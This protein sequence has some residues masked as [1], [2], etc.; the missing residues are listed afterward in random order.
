[1]EGWKKVNGRWTFK[2]EYR[3]E[4]FDCGTLGNTCER[5]AVR[6]MGNI[7]RTAETLVEA[8]LMTQDHFQD[9]YDCGDDFGP[10]RDRS[11]PS[12]DCGC[13]LAMAD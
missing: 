3:I 1:M 12:C 2:V 6:W 11:E 4:R 8:A 5:W 13:G 10:V 9:A 7:I